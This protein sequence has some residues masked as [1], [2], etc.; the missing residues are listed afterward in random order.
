MGGGAGIRISARVNGFYFTAQHKHAAVEIESWDAL[1]YEDGMRDIRGD[2]L[3]ATAYFEITAEERQY[4]REHWG[5]KQGERLWCPCFTAEEIIFAGWVR[6]PWQSRFPLTIECH[7]DLE[8]LGWKEIQVEITPVNK[9][10]FDEFWQD[11][12]GFIAEDGLTDDDGREI[13]LEEQ[14]EWHDYDNRG[15]YGYREK[16]HA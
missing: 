15:N 3:K 4:L 6:G 16:Q 2:M 8:F 5:V 13:T 10:E 1:G 7:V 9:E 14:Y 12:F 11:V